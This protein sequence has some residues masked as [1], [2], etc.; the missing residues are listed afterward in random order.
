MHSPL[1][2]A[3]WASYRVEEL[4]T[5]PSFS[6]KYSISFDWSWFLVAIFCR[7][8]S[9]SLQ[10]HVLG[11]T[12]CI[13]KSSVMGAWSD[14]VMGPI[15]EATKWGNR[16]AVSRKKDLSEST[17]CVEGS[18]RYIAYVWDVSLSMHQISYTS[19]LIS[20]MRWTVCGLEVVGCFGRVRVCLCWGTCRS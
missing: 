5:E 7:R 16:G 9:L 19:M 15:S 11:S 17:F 4:K 18:R 14:H 10:W 2:K 8:D 3:L 1:K 20:K 12:E 13:A 6:W